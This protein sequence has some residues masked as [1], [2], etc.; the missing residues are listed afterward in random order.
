[1]TDL[2]STPDG[3]F[4]DPAAEFLAARDALLLH[5]TD[6]AK[7]V[8]TF[9]WPRPEHF[10]WAL[11]Y[12]DT[13]AVRGDRDALRV[14]GLGGPATDRLIGYGELSRRSAQVANRLRGLGV[15]RG[16]TVLLMLGNRAEVWETMLAAIKLGAVVIPTYTTATPV[17]SPTG[18]TGAG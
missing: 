10:N 6:L 11:D 5:R 7:A 3:L 2:T 15:R 18:W 14:V 17:N 16:E 8:E 12:F 4:Q 13:V 9:R 1:M